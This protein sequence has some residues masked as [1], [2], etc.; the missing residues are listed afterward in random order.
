MFNNFCLTDEEILKIIID[1]KY[2]IDA[3]SYVNS[4][5]DEDLNQEI[6]ICLWRVLSA[7]RKKLKNF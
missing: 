3:K 2:L 4:R 7:N 1:Y 5:F 6:K